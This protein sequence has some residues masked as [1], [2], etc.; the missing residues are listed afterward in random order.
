M[1]E[2]L[3]GL[4]G[5]PATKSNIS[6]IDGEGGILGQAG[7]SWVHSGSSSE[8]WIPISGEMDF[9]TGKL[10]DVAHIAIND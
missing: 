4:A 10:V 9:D 3:P 5:V 2:Y 7:P 1:S 6:D 8:P